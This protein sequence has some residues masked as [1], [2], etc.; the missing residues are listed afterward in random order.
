MAERSTAPNMSKVPSQD[1]TPA[2]QTEPSLAELAPA[3][4]V[5][6]ASYNA[7]ILT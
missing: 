1:E 5:I 6:L 4:K 2:T 3:P 7:A